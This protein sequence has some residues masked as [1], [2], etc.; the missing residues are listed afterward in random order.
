ME[1]GGYFTSENKRVIEKFTRKGNTLVYEVTV[2]DPDVL[3]EPW[4]LAPRNLRINANRD[5]GLV[6]EATPCRDYD[7]ANMVTQIR[8]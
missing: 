1:K 5:A 8:H 3:A 7:H 2:E 6:N 4:V